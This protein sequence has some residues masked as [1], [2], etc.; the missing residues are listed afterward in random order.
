MT[1]GFY[2]DYRLGGIPRHYVSR[3][4]DK[5][6]V[7]DEVRKCVVFILHRDKQD[8]Q[9]HLDGTGFFVSIK[10]EDLNFAY[11]I[12]AKHVIVPIKQRSVDNIVYLRINTRDGG[13]QLVATR[14]NDW[15]DHPTDSSVDAMLLPYAPP[16]DVFDY[17][18]IT[19]QMV[20]TESVIR[21]NSIGA[22]DEVFFTGLFV[23]AY[24]QKKNMPIVRIGNIALIPDEKIPIKYFGN[25]DVYLIESRSIGGLSGSPVF[26]HLGGVRT[27]PGKGT[28]LGGSLFFFLGL[29]HGHWEIDIEKT[30]IDIGLSTN[31]DEF[32]EEKEAVNKGIAIV[33]P[34]VKIME[35]IFQ[36]KLQQGRDKI[37]QERKEKQLPIADVTSDNFDSNG[38]TKEEFEETLKKISRP[39]QPNEQEKKET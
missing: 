28:M 17:L 32:M 34:A 11:V 39:L 15:I 14:V 5:M 8:D 25:A 27:V 38:I 19:E 21:D 33:V 13:S 2:T 12:T 37:I 30:K 9:F 35:T 29:I 20:A 7:P 22:G 18:V 3:E 23:N 4:D 24:G 31:E 1:L 6:L 26:V 10:Q 16:L 36:P